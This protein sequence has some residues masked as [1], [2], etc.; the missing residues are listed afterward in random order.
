MI[1][2]NLDI[3]PAWLELAVKGHS[4]QSARLK[5]GTDFAVV[6][7]MVSA[8]AQMCAYGLQEYGTE[9]ELIEYRAGRLRVRARNNIVAQALMES[10]VKTL[11]AIK[12]R[13]P[14]EFVG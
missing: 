12:Q 4:G 8:V 6:C 10:C 13:F 2:Y 11:N 1:S 14:G 5:D 7:G 3:K 9:C